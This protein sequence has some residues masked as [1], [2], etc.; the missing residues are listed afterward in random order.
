LFFSFLFFFFTY[1][2]QIVKIQQL[3]KH[4][5]KHFKN[6]KTDPHK[7]FTV[8]GN[9]LDPYEQWWRIFPRATVT[10]GAWVHAPPHKTW[11]PGGS[12]SVSSPLPFSAGGDNAVTCKTTK[13]QHRQLIL[14]FISFVFQIFFGFFLF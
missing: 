9:L 5:I 8:Q 3:N 10:G 12:G 14:V 6:Y 4:Y 11:K 13:T 7:S 1:T 2:V